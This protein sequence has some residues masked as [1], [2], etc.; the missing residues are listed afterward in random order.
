MEVYNHMR[1][2]GRLPT[3]VANMEA[4]HSTHSVASGLW[5][6]AD[7]QDELGSSTL[8]C[9]YESMHNDDL[10]SAL[11]VAARVQDGSLASH[12]HTSTLS[13]HQGVFLNL[14]KVVSAHLAQL[15]SGVLVLHETLVTQGL[16]VRCPSSTHSLNP[17]GSRLIKTLN[18]RMHQCP[19]ADDFSIPHAGGVYFPAHSCIQAKEHRNVMQILPH[20]LKGLDDKGEL[21]RLA[22]SY[23]VV[24]LVPHPLSLPCL[25]CTGTIHPCPPLLLAGT[26]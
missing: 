20:I 1:K 16:S 8:A 11:Q 26:L 4:Q 13:N 21:V 18:A 9:A 17:A 3:E 2:P 14:V 12:T 7:S 6:F 5:G 15:P 10:V 23:V 22:S 24:P 19:R 25:G